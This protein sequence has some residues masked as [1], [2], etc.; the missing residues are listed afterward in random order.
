MGTPGIIQSLHE[1]SE[2]T[3]FFLE[4]TDQIENRAKDGIWELSALLSLAG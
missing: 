2:F 4:F 3:M 1:C